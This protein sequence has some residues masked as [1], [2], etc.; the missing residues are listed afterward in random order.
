M[1]KVKFTF[2]LLIMFHAAASAQ[3][4]QQIEG[5]KGYIAITFGPS[6][7]TGDFGD[8]SFD[9]EQ[10]GM[11]VNG[12]QYSIAEFGIKFIPHFGMVAAI[13]GAVL[14]L[15]V[16]ALADGYAEVNGGQFIVKSTRWG[17][18]M[19]AVGPVITIPSKW[20]EVDFRLLT[21]LMMAASPELNINWDG[22]DVAGQEAAVGGS[23]AFGLGAGIRVHVS[24]RVSLLAQ[25]EYMTASPVFQTTVYNGNTVETGSFEKQFTT[26][27]LNFGIGYRIF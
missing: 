21:G 25:G 14:P 20:I 12:Y 6:Y 23:F 7:P 24:Q 10:S 17:Y 16:Q 13:K 19:L 3:E 9:S 18:T 27:G 26:L 1:K 22:V 11:A 4:K 8:N 15:D 2:L 5:R